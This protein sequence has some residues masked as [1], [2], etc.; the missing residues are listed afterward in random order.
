MQSC[1]KARNIITI[2][3]IQTC[4]SFK[5]WKQTPSKITENGIKGG[6]FVL[7]AYI[8]NIQCVLLPLVILNAYTNT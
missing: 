8:Y 3:L 1:R 5:A 2:K 6:L 7:V 4:N